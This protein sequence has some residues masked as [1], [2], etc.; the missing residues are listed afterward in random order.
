[1]THVWSHKRNCCTI[2][3]TLLLMGCAAP[4]ASIPSTITLSS[5]VITPTIITDFSPQTQVPFT[6]YA[7]TSMLEQMH[8]TS[9]QIHDDG[10]RILVELRYQDT[11]KRDALLVLNGKANCCLDAAGKAVNPITLANG[12][13]AYYLPNEP[14]YGGN[15]LWWIHDG[16]Y[17]A[18]SG[19][20]ITKD[21][22]VQL[23]NTIKPLIN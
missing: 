18:L 21:M 4:Q 3:F 11:Q 23:A 2:I 8:Q 13:T 17:I 5:P 19:P 22:L 6:V 16:T 7:P 10:S 12:E 20:Q 15:I 14:I 1:M 9:A